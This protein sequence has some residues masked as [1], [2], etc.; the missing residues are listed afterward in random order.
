MKVGL[1][2]GSFNPVHVGHLI[3]ANH[4]VNYTNLDQVW[5]VV[6]PQNPFK[7]ATSLLN[8]YQRLHMVNVAI[9]GEN[10]L[11]AS[12][13]EFKLPKPSYTIDTLTYLTEKYPD[14]QFSILM[15]SDGFQNINKWKNF[16]TLISNY[17]FFI[18]K[19]PDFE[20]EQ[21]FGATITIVDAPLLDISS[22][23]IRNMIRDKKSIRFLVPDSVKNE[24]ESNGYYRS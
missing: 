24:I 1:Y 23:R 3:I 10:K 7:P 21:D 2:F 11:R 20:I 5:F 15:G 8:E 16:E 14:H 4:F 6:S 13:V 12:N 17:S 9:D 19:R 18:Y 22:T